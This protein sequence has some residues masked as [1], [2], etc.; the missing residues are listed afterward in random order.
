MTK[1][2]ELLGRVMMTAVSIPRSDE[3]I[4]TLA[5]TEYRKADQ[6]FIMYCLKADKPLDVR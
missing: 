2:A 1:L 4:R 3:D 6:D 5:R